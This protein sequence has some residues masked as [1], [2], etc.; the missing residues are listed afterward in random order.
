MNTKDK[1]LA[2]D[3]V[4]INEIINLEKENTINSKSKAF[5]EKLGLSFDLGN[6]KTKP[7][8]VLCNPICIV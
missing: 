1:K 8:E 2:F 5:Q 6:N 4:T 3:S 7:R